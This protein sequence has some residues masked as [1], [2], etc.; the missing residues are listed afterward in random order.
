MLACLRLVA[1]C[2]A[3]YEGD[4]VAVVVVE[5]YLTRVV[6]VRALQ[7]LRD[8]SEREAEVDRPVTAVRIKEAHLQKNNKDEF[9]T[10]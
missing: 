2:V 10:L 9:I 5:A 4:R 7:R 1:L 6:V 8:V 3:E